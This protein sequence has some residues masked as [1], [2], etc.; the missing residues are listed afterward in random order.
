MNLAE[1]WVLCF[2]LCGELELRAL[3]FFPCEDSE[4]RGLDFLMGIFVKLRG[5]QTH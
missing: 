2:F 4:V 5:T 3:N 1:L